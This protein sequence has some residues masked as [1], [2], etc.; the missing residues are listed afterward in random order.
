MT[1]RPSI[2]TG[3]PSGTKEAG[4]RVD[5]RPDKF[6]LAIVTKGYRMWWSRAGICPCR[7]NVQTDQANVNC[8][9]C[10]GTGWFY[11][12]PELGLDA[13]TEDEHGNALE[14]SDDGDAVGISV[15]CTSATLDPQIYERFGEWAFGTI[16]M[17]TQQENRLG[18]RDRLVMRDS[19]MV[20]G[21]L[22]EFDGAATIPITGGRSNAG[23]R[24]PAVRTI[25]LARVEGTTRINYREGVDYTIA[26]DGSLAWSVTPPAATTLFISY[27]INPVFRIL[28]HVFAFRDS[29]VAL[30]TKALTLAE[31]H[32][33]L[34]VHAMARLD[35]L[36]DE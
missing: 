15:L 30:K 25:L 16:K 9:I 14:I 20:W 23:L 31:Q 6:D 26:S 8:A 35:F 29:P 22:I 36:V 1:M 5:F 18:Y 21:Q 11:F 3:L 17:S 32:R 4:Q 10:S 2:I 27:V 13:F 24:Y 28:D 19:E 33:K 7:N 12:L 34:P